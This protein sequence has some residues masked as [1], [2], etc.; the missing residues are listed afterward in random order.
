M[1]CMSST[2]FQTTNF[3]VNWT[4]TVNQKAVAARITEKDLEMFTV[5]PVK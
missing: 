4:V 5:S 2:D 1:P 3:N